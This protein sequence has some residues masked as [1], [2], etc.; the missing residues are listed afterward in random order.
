MTN[1]VAIAFA[2]TLGAHENE[3]TGH[4]GLLEGERAE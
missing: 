1:D 2:R 3:P 4:G